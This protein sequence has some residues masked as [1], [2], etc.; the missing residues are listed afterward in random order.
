[1]AESKKEKQQSKQDTQ[2]KKQVQSQQKYIDDLVSIITPA[3][4]GEKYIAETIESVLA[5]TYQHWEMLI[6]N[7]YSTDN[8][9]QIVQSYAAKDKRIKLLNLNQ[10]SGVVVARNTAIQN[11]KGRY[12]AFLDSD[13]LWKKEKLKK[14][15]EFMQQN[16]YAFMFTAYEHF[17]D[18]KENIQNKVEAPSSLNYKQALKGNQIGCLTVMLDRKQIKNIEFSQQKH[19]DY[20]L[21]LNILK[22]GITAYGIQESLALYRTGNSKSISGNKLQS[23]LWTL[24]VYRESQKLP[25]LK[26]MYYMWFYVVNGLRKYRCIRNENRYNN[27]F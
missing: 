9:I 11:A 22:Q 15:L 23:A 27:I 8:T 3:Y 2:S 17:K 13:D 7:D 24:K 26:S 18:N 21:W 25:L 4:N 1:M 12:I 20:I 5:Q 10:N 16:G 14:Q 19:E 6:V